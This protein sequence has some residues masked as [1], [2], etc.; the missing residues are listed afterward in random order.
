MGDEKTMI[1]SKRKVLNNITLDGS[2]KKVNLKKYNDFYLIALKKDK[3][4]LKKDT[5]NKECVKKIRFEIAIASGKKNKYLT[6][7]YLTLNFNDMTSS[8]ASLNNITALAKVLNFPSTFYI[9]PIDITGE[10]STVTEG[11]CSIEVYINEMRLK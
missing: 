4:N 6:T 1:N 2:W 5:L 11:R 8:D 7:N 3:M 9:R 10:T